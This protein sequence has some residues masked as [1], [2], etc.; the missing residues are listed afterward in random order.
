MVPLQIRVKQAQYLYV[1]W[2]NGTKTTVTLEK[3]RMFCPCASCITSREKMGKKYIPIYNEKQKRVA[4]VTQIGSY[5][6]QIAWEDGH[7]QGI[8]EYPFL[9]N[10]AEDR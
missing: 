9:K 6:I 4:A 10:L 5:A 7:N 2:D 1:A 3:L 8:Y